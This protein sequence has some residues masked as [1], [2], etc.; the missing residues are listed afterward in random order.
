MSEYTR[1]WKCPECGTIVEHSYEALADVGMPLCRECDEEMGLLPETYGMSETG[2][3]DAWRIADESEQDEPYGIRIVDAQ[4]VTIM[5]IWQN[6]LDPPRWAQQN[7]ENIVMLSN[8]LRGIDVPR[9]IVTVTGGV[10]E[11]DQKP[12]GI[13]AILV[14]Y[15][16]DGC[17]KDHDASFSSLGYYDKHDSWDMT[18]GIEEINEFLEGH[19]K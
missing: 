10:A 2:T 8:A 14:D 11:I 19:G 1:K 15:D 5:T 3:P 17:E 9:V 7:A 12:L 16:N 6:P 4:D 18:D 13:E